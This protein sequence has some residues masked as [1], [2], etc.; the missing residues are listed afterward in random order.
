[1]QN[2]V[3]AELLDAVSLAPWG[4][5]FV[6]HVRDHPDAAIEPLAEPWLTAEGQA[7]F[8][9]QIAQMDQR[10]TDE[11]EPRYGTITAPTLIIWGEADRWLPL[12][13]GRALHAATRD[14]LLRFLRDVYP[15]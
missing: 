6:Q 2:Q 3:L 10:Y 11:V 14:R 12:E 9:R 5:P 1:M 13:Q 4:S 15:A 8:Y 7:A